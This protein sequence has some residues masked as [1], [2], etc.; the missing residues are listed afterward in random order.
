MTG[1]AGRQ[2]SC[3]ACG[4]TFVDGEKTSLEVLI[5]GMVRYVA[6]CW[7]CHSSPRKTP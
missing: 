7:D 2:H 5:D 6:V 1:Q 4:H 3:A